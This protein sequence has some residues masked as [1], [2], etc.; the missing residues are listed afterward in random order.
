MSS[1]RKELRRFPRRQIK[2]AKSSDGQ[3]PYRSEDSRRLPGTFLCSL[4][5]TVKSLEK[6]SSYLVD[7]TRRQ[8]AEAAS[9][10]KKIIKCEICDVLKQVSFN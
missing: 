6:F 4:R 5:E 7:F 8:A 9:C 1:R 10:E 3:T 2:S